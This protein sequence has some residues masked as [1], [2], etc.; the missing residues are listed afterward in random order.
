[1]KRLFTSW[2]SGGRWGGR[3]FRW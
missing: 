3:R 1:M 2:I